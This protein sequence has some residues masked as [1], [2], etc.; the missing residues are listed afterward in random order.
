V[1]FLLP[2]K[3]PALTQPGCVADLLVPP[4]YPTEYLFELRCVAENIS[5]ERGLHSEVHPPASTLVPQ[6]AP[7][8]EPQVTDAIASDG[9]CNVGTSE[10]SGVEQPAVDPESKENAGNAPSSGADAHIGP[11]W[12]NIPMTQEKSLQDLPSQLDLDWQDLV[13]PTPMPSLAARNP[14]EE[15]EVVGSTQNVEPPVVVD[16][17][18][19]VSQIAQEA[20]VGAM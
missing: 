18:A 17:F 20:V 7:Q 3:V 13:L 8:C 6:Q 4:H 10:A 2:Y 19:E 16:T 5:R 11:A 12:L 1:I 15:L 14:G 9:I